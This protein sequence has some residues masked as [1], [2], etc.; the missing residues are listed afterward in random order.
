MLISVLSHWR[1]LRVVTSLLN[2]H[3]IVN[4]E[5]MPAE[6]VSL[7]NATLHNTSNGSCQTDVEAG[8]PAS[9]PET[10]VQPSSGKIDILSKIQ[11]LI[12][13]KS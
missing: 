12:C 11:I 6:G 1:A 2:V 3:T 5:S 4:A 9:S 10:S 8:Q 13:Y 7:L